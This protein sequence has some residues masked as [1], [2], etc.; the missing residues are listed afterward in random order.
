VCGQAGP[1]WRR[2]RCWRG[3][4][5]G[6]DFL[7]L[8]RGLEG[9]S[10]PPRLRVITSG[11]YTCGRLSGHDLAARDVQGDPGDP[12]GRVGGEEQ[13]R[14]G[15]IGGDT[16]PTQWETA[17]LWCCVLVGR[18]AGATKSRTATAP[19]L[20]LAAEIARW[21]AVRDDCED[22]RPKRDLLLLPAL[23]SLAH[24]AAIV[25]GAGAARRSRSSCGRARRTPSQPIAIANTCRLPLVSA[26]V[27]SVTNRT[28]LAGL[29]GIEP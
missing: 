3:E 4:R 11:R 6:H 28:V 26:L 23:P 2:P 13:C 18:L 7:P 21:N 1:V 17:A 9:Q 12:G 5:S 19:V 8:G 29:S 10:P 20:G 16:Q 15:D 27:G 24:D 25:T 22:R 14:F